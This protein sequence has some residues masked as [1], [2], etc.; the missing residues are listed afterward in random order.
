MSWGL[1][2][3]YFLCLCLGPPT[4]GLFGTTHRQWCLRFVSSLSL[5]SYTN[6]AAASLT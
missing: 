5:R 2:E 3:Q 4:Q 1:L 6:L